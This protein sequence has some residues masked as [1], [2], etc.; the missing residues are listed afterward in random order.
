MTEDRITRPGF[1][2]PRAEARPLKMEAQID[3]CVH[4]VSFVGFG[5]G[6]EINSYELAASL[7]I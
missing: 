2:A 1:A 6:S 5:R 4:V 7:G 3:L